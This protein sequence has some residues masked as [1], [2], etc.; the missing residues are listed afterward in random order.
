MKARVDGGRQEEVE[1]DQGHYG[2]LTADFN[3]VGTR[4]LHFV[5]SVVAAVLQLCVR[6]VHVCG[7]PVLEG[8]IVFA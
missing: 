2:R 6:G 4:A 5:H 8:E 3:E 7:Q 1:L